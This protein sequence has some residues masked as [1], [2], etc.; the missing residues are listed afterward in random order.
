MC[1]I[2]RHVFYKATKYVNLNLNDQFLCVYANV[3]FNIYI[4]MCV[5]VCVWLDV[6][7][8]EYSLYFILSVSLP[9][10][11]ISLVHTHTYIF[12]L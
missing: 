10:S 1:I 5:C 9:F 11:S 2:Y 3:S 4:N 8:S 7:V 12:T 6:R